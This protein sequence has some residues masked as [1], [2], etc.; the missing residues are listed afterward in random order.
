MLEELIDG[1]KQDYNF[2]GSSYDKQGKFLGH[3]YLYSKT[4]QAL[5]TQVDTLKN[6]FP[7][8]NITHLYLNWYII[9]FNKTK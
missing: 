7:E 8:F 9:G 1:I 5:P 6:V 3:H 2:V 4:I